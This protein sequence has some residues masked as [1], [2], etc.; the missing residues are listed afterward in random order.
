MS[1]TKI[2]LASILKP[3]DDTRMY[4]KIGISLGQTNKYEINIIG[5]YTKKIPHPVSSIKLQPL[6]NFRRTDFRR[7]I[8]PVK[9][10]MAYIKAKPQIIIVNT[11][12]L[13]IVTVL[14]K[15]LFGCKMC[16]D[17]Q[18]NYYRNLLYGTG[19]LRPLRPAV[20]SWVRLKEYATRRWV[21][22]Y[23]LA[24]RS[25]E[26][27]FTFT[28]NKSVIIENK[29]QPLGG[30]R[31]KTVPNQNM[32]LAFSG[33]LAETTG[34]FR[35]IELAI[36][37]HTLNSS[38]RL[39]I[40]GH[41]AQK[42]TLKRIKAYLKKYPFISLRGGGYIVPHKEVI[43]TVRDADFGMISYPENRS[44]KN[45]IPTKLYEYLAL[46]L[47]IILQNHETWEE[48][49]QPYKACIAVDYDNAD[50]HMLLKKMMTGH[51]YT[52]L[53]GNEVLWYSEEE[54]LVNSI[55]QLTV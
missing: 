17:V 28:H 5:F 23:L 48:I 41:C 6:F 20:A 19:F 55:N 1:K 46:Q 29:H 21:D 53:P 54:K 47:P 32:V 34:V 35:A 51:F 11:H 50:E 52:S 18:E 9:C 40:V 37:L 8:A 33:T 25:Y 49:C 13:L 38:I 30:N 10:F 3:V 14:Y 39:V 24:E 7:I 16:Y 2:I 22:L 15:I 44:T 27:E 43:E 42:S 12:E 26:K 4:E 45:S 31:K 36:R